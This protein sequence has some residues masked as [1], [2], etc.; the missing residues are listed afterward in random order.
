MIEGAHYNRGMGYKFLKHTTRT[1]VN[2]F[3]IDINGFKLN[4]KSDLRSAFETL[5]IL[6]KVYI[7]TEPAKTGDGSAKIIP[8]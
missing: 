5:A 3:M 4:V 2:M 8:S 7:N 6:N 1:K